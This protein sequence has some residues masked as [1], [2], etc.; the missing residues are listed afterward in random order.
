[1]IRITVEDLETGETE[2]KE[3]DNDFC[4]TV[5]GNRY[6]DGIQHYPTKGTTVLTIKTGTG[7]ASAQTAI[8]TR[9]GYRTM[10][11]G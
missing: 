1:M 9:D 11:G 10:G 8:L 6:L 2:V 4:L 7:T 3:F 5:A